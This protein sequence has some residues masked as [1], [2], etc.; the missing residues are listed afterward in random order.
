[1][2]LR[3]DLKRGV[4]DNSVA[5]SIAVRRGCVSERLSG[6][7]ENIPAAWP[8]TDCTS[9]IPGDFR[10]YPLGLRAVFSPKTTPRNDLDSIPEVFLTS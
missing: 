2:C 9:D 7:R 10:S 6:A 4:V 8:C 3:K 1:M 5:P